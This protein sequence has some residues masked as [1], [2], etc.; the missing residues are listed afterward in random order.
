M[1]DVM[2]EE[3]KCSSFSKCSSTG[4][5]PA[6]ALASTWLK[7]GARASEGLRSLLLPNHKSWIAPL[8]RPTRASILRLPVT[9]LSIIL[10]RYGSGPAPSIVC[11]LFGIVKLAADRKQPRPGST[12]RAAHPPSPEDPPGLRRR[13]Q[14]RRT[15]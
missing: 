7:Y 8:G 10:P 13:N 4:T 1:I 5:F 2:V 12:V 11:G 9:R 3:L 14:V 15:C 6:V